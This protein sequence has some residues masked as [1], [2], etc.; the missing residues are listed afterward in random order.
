MNKIVIY[1]II[2][3]LISLSAYPQKIVISRD[4]K[5][6]TGDDPAWADPALD[7]SGWD[8]LHAG[9]WWAHAGYHYSGFAWYR[10]SI[11]IPS[12]LKKEVKKKGTLKLTLGE[13]Q[14]VD[15]TFFNGKMIG[16][17]GSLNPFEGKW[18]SL[19]EY[20]IPSGIVNWDAENL[21]AVRVYG[22]GGNGG[23]HT[24]PYTLEPYRITAKDHITAKVRTAE[25][26]EVHT[27]RF[28]MDFRNNGKENYRGTVIFSLQDSLHNEIN[29]KEKSIVLVSGTTAR[30]S[31]LYE[32]PSSGICHLAGF[33]K[34]AGTGVEIKR[35]ITI[36]TIR[37]IELPVAASM[38]EMLIKNTIADRYIPAPFE[39]LELKGLA[40]EWLDINLN[41]RLLQIDEK[42]ILA[43][44]MNRPGKQN[45]I[46]EHIGKYLEAASN[47]WRY[48]HDPR[49]KQQMDRMVVNLLAT[50]KEDG[51]LGTY[52]PRQYWM[53]WDVWVHKYN[54]AGLLA[55]YSATGYKP[56]LKAAVKIGDLLCRTFGDEPGQKD[57]ILSGTHVGMAS[58]SVLDPVV[59]LYRYTGDGKYLDFARYIVRAYDHPDGPRIVS[60]LL[61]EGK[62]NEVANGK[63][64]EMLSNLIGLI[65][66]YEVTGEEKLISAVKIA[67][68]DIVKNR[69]YITGTTSSYEL[70]GADHE[71][72]AGEDAHMGEGCVTTHWFQF[73]YHLFRLTGDLRYYDQLEKTMYNHLTG[74][75]NPQTG[76]VSYYT[77]LQDMKPYSCGITCCLS[78]VPW[79]ISMLPLISYGEL[80]GSP[81][82]LLTETGQ[83]ID[84]V[85]SSTGEKIPLKLS[86]Q[87]EFPDSGKLECIV[88]P[89]KEASFSLS[90]R[91][92]AWS[93]NFVAEC[94]DTIL[95]GEPGKMVSLNRFWKKGD[96]VKIHFDIPVKV[97][98]GGMSY[99]GYAAIKRGP[100]VL[101]ADQGLNVADIDHVFL[102]AGSSVNL[103]PASS[104][105]KK[106]PP[107]W[108]GHQLYLVE[109][110]FIPGKNI[111][112]FLVPYSDAG[113][114]GDRI[115]V[116]LKSNFLHLLKVN[117]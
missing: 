52:L 42:E 18:G 25:T 48:T 105:G 46:G 101:A 19:R 82:I 36:S 108:V 109:I 88:S 75:E 17:T 56:A 10:K 98:Q 27:G 24:G 85:I 91:V 58:T 51:Y 69:L 44:F 86:L 114:E 96:R 38:P 23:L 32:K 6:R 89:V 81:A 72:P 84:T 50:Q 113:Q 4:W 65:K 30:D 93:E 26:G 43:G 22:R 59:D 97:L 14:D 87:S 1:G 107:S 63:A 79:G 34:E 110:L 90:Y 76:C 13:I 61:E 54:M 8:D 102:S 2:G 67:W 112:V 5:F 20:F 116:W 41:R 100:Q 73:N 47:T 104:V 28:I 45:W 92:P 57:I 94:G 64:Y 74:A 68:E 95:H 103:S 78:S 60:G 11:F 29:R 77:P 37:E 12:S 106:L 53:D 15:Q 49:L 66:L 35:E 117:L 55:Y 21:I 80:N 40:G 70:F 111:N 33:F 9:L 115:S 16:Q 31:F 39:S 3:L 7:D 62:V 99:P 71:L 83:I